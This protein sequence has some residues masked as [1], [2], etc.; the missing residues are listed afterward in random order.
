[1]SKWFPVNGVDFEDGDSSVYQT[2]WKIGTVDIS[3]FQGQE[4]SN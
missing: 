2:N 1:M 4:S 3:E